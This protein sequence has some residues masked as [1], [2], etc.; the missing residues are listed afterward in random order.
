MGREEEAR[1]LLGRLRGETGE[2]A[3]RAEAEFQ[4][5]RNA[6]AIE[7][8]ANKTKSDSY[9]NIITGR[10]FGKLHVGRRVQLVIWLQIM[11][12]WVGIAG[13]TVCKCPYLK[14]VMESVTNNFQ[15]TPRP[16]SVSL[17]LMPVRVSGFP[18]LTMSFTW[19]V[20]AELFDT[21]SIPNTCLVCN[22]HLC[23]H[24]GSHRS[25]Q[26]PLLGFHWPRHCHVP[27][28]RFLRHRNASCRRRQRW[29]S[30]CIRC[31]RSLY[32]LHLHLRFRSNLVDRPMALPS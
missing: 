7:Q 11:Q 4:D 31:C 21:L 10:G 23:L 5:I 30:I 22:P 13:V 28:W 6:M 24:P 18:V 32:D 12:E 8:N 19:Y 27:R 3:V 17:V 20:N 26:D 25:P 9:F 2:D 1:W 16:S 14:P 15:K 29:Q